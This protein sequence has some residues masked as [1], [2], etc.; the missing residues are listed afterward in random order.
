M[1][2]K[3]KC[4]IQCLAHSTEIISHYHLK[5][6]V[7]KPQTNQRLT[8]I[9]VGRLAFWFLKQGNST[10]DLSIILPPLEG[11]NYLVI[12]AI[13]VS[14]N[15]MGSINIM[16]ATSA[17]NSSSW[18]GISNNSTSTCYSWVISRDILLSIWLCIQWT[19]QACSTPRIMRRAEAKVASWKLVH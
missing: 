13:S 19:A 18:A 12:Y 10:T 4:P 11:L 1:V 5:R 3:I 7:K 15:I 9:L 17:G 16:T 2:V 6:L 14:I 8:N